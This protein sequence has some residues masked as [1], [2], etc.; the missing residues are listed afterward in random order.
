MSQNV[1]PLFRTKVEFQYAKRN[2]KSFFQQKQQQKQRLTLTCSRSLSSCASDSVSKRRQPNIRGNTTNIQVIHWPKPSAP[3]T[4]GC[5]RPAMHFS[6]LKILTSTLTCNRE[7][8]FC[9]VPAELLRYS[10]P[11]PHLLP[12]SNHPPLCVHTYLSITPV[13][14]A[15]LVFTVLTYAT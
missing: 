5:T 14:C 15:A 4:R 9:C 13:L 7:Y 12:H 2:K 10:A 8:S 6:T 1:A 11:L 3:E